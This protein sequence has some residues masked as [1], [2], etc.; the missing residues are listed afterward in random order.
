MAPAGKENTMSLSIPYEVV[1]ETVKK[2]LLQAGLTEEQAE[3]CAGIHAQSSADGVE[4]HGLNRIPRFVQYIRRGWVDLDGKPEKKGAKGAVENYDGHLG[5]GILN[6]LFCFV[7]AVELAKVHGIGCVTLRNTTH[8][9]R[10]GTY[11]WRMAEAGYAGICWINTE[12]CMP[13]WGSDEQG[14]GNNPFCIALPRDQGPVVLDMAMSQYAYGKLG[15][16]RLAGKQL[17]FPGGFDKDGNLTTDPGA[18]QESRR[19]LPMGY[20]KGSAMALAL[21]LAAA[22]LANGNTGTDMDELGK[23]SC[24]SCCQIFI[25]FDPYLFGEKE[26][27]QKKMDKRIEAAHASHPEREGGRVSYPGERT[28]ATRT[29]SMEQGV[30]VDEQIWEQVCSIAE[31][32][33][34]VAD[35]S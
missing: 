4:S 35:I 6:G 8:W 15:V 20:W 14:V 32:N 27:I 24:G 30:A 11:A 2:A 9:M 16:Y 34:D 25:A 22:M 13:L 31:G 28:I 5:I 23:G 21:D 18:I 1:K 12:S 7:R 29:K 26:E 3:I 33:L 10:G 17:P 19:I